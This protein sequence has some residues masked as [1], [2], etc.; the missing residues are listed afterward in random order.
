MK[1]I[2]P[3][4]GI[5]MITLGIWINKPLDSQVIGFYCIAC[6]GIIWFF[7]DLIIEAIEKKNNSAPPKG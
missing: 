1:Y 4:I 3:T 6:V 2:T 5:I 7:V